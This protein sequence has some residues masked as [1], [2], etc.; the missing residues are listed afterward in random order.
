MERILAFVVEN[1]FIVV[2]PAAFISAAI[3]HH[4]PVMGHHRQPSHRDEEAC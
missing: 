4:W 3:A 2:I 1:I